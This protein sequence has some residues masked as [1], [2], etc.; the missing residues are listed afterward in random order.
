MAIAA[1]ILGACGSSASPSAPP[2]PANPAMEAIAVEASAAP[3]ADE[4]LDPPVDRPV[5]VGVGERFSCARYESGAV[6]CWGSNSQGRAGLGERTDSTVPVRVEGL[7]PATAL[8]VGDTHACILDASGTPTCWGNNDLGQVGSAPSSFL[9]PTAVAVSAAVEIDASARHTCVRTEEGVV[10]CW[11][12]AF[13]AGSTDGPTAPREIRGI[14]A[15]SLELGP[16]TSCA[17]LDDRS[18]SCWGYAT[19][20]LFGPASGPFARPRPITRIPDLHVALLAVGDAHA[21]LV[22]EEGTLICGGYDTAGELIDQSVPDHARCERDT[23]EVTC[24]WVSDLA[25]PRGVRT[26]PLQ[27]YIEPFPRPPSPPITQTYP[28]QPGF[29][30]AHEGHHTLLLEADGEYRLGRT[31]IGGPSGVRCWGAFRRADWAHRSD[32]P[33]I[34]GTAHVQQFDVG[35][36]HGCALVTPTAAHATVTCWGTNQSGELGDGTT[37]SRN[38]SLPIAPFAR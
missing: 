37:E 32:P 20:G 16:Q 30:R 2:E 6:R 9:P 28:A 14:R 13:V 27:P 11:G 25:P 33:P 21:C 4:A 36:D 31:C 19:T 18:L 10:F 22:D 15:I 29:G 1:W 24:T 23:Y 7:P 38:T 3:I 26:D 8:A 34:E 5:E 17:V 12:G 35:P